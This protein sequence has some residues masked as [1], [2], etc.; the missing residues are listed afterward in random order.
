MSITEDTRELEAHDRARAPKSAVNELGQGGGDNRKV[1]RCATQ[2]KR[3]DERQH[4][5][6]KL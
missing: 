1:E 5:E 3:K 6:K 4:K 2:G